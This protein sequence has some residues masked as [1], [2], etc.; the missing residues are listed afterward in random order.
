MFSKRDSNFIVKY[1]LNLFDIDVNKFPY[2]AL[3]RT[4]NFEELKNV[5]K[6]Y[7]FK[8]MLVELDIEK[9]K[10]APLPL[11][12][13]C[14][15]ETREYFTCINLVDSE[16]V[17]CYD[18]V[19]GHRNLKLDN[20]SKIWKGKAILVDKVGDHRHLSKYRSKTSVFNSCF[21][22]FLALIS[23]S[24]IN[25]IS[26]IT[27]TIWIFAIFIC[28]A[29][30]RHKYNFSVGG[31]WNFN[32][33]HLGPNDS[34]GCKGQFRNSKLVGKIG[35]TEAGFSYYI[36]S[37]LSLNVLPTAQ[38]YWLYIS[39]LGVVFIVFSLYKQVFI[40]GEYCLLCLGLSILYL[41]ELVLH[42]SHWNKGYI[43]T[44]DIL[45]LLVIALV[46][47][48]IVYFFD[49]LLSQSMQLLRI[50]C[51]EF[52]LKS[53]IRWN[54]DAYSISSVDFSKAPKPI[55]CNKYSD[56]DIVSIIVSAKCPSCHSVLE[57]LLLI[58]S[59]CSG[60]KFHVYIYPSKSHYDILAERL[61]E[62]NSLETL[63]F[64]YKTGKLKLG[65]P[66]TNY[67]RRFLIWVSNYKIETYPTLFL[68]G[69]A[70][71]AYVALRDLLF[72]LE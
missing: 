35:L 32:L 3:C 17:R 42:F 51:N 30:I 16:Y 27:C 1:F 15:F 69:R 64:Y 50:K 58:K 66:K 24:F 37:L 40:F 10:K 39:A 6:F 13:K 49:S 59:V 72:Q 11:L 55:I 2:P 20:F 61:M 47:T 18:V 52:R 68:N 38:S 67:T 9:L 43:P 65:D 60:T 54:S 28:L 36:F 31:I 12:A 45:K 29:L 4:H 71:P 23:L 48:L 8:S 41:S 25:G 19:S 46:T 34:K 14:T 70:L 57:D 7:G 53:S 62:S 33:C 56:G 44:S 63:L 21:L 26:A 5:L 22:A